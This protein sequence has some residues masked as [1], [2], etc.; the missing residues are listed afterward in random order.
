MFIHF[1]NTNYY[2]DQYTPY[3]PQGYPHGAYHSTDAYT[4][5]ASGAPIHAPRYTYDTPGCYFS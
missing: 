1:Q 4:S 2:T 5:D 3:P